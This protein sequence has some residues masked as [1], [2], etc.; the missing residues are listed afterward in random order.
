MHYWPNKSIQKTIDNNKIK[1][2]NRPKGLTE[3]EWQEEVKN[4]KMNKLITINAVP[5]VSL[6]KASALREENKN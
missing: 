2:G 5:K 6:K 3:E 4:L 1:F